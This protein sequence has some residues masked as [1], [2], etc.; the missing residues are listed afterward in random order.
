MDQVANTP[1]LNVVEAN[2]LFITLIMKTIIKSLT[3]L[4]ANATIFKVVVITSLLRIISLSIRELHQR[5][6]YSLKQI[7]THHQTHHQTLYQLRFSNS[8]RQGI[9]IL[10]IFSFRYLMKKR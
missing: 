5:A 3:L 2:V 1:V 6:T 7:R 10:R 4:V 8:Q 9:I